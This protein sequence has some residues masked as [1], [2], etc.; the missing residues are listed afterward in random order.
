[1]FT[2]QTA[3]RFALTCVMSL[4]L[5]ACLLDSGTELNDNNSQS[6]TNGISLAITSPTSATTM[7]TTDSTVSLAGTAGSNS[8]IAGVSWRNDRGG[9]GAASGTDNW[10]TSSIALQLGQNAITVTAEDTN[11]NTH[12]RNIVVNRESGELGSATLSWAAPTTRTDGSALTNLSG[13]KIYYGRMSETYDY[14]VDITNPGVLTYVVEGLASGE[15]FF[16]LSA[17]DADDLESNRTDE[18]SWHIS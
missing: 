4:T 6:A 10:Q 7:D 15:W 5:S 18:V 11:G 8:G 9:Q 12:S 3:A 2:Y 14:S 13:Y 16:A 17:Y 1:M